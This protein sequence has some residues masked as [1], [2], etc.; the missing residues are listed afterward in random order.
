MCISLQLGLLLSL[1]CILEGK[2]VAA[3]IVSHTLGVIVK[4]DHEDIELTLYTKVHK[5]L[6]YILLLLAKCDIFFLRVGDGLTP[7]TRHASFY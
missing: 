5:P 6:E 1:E 3:C 4:G 7:E 2:I